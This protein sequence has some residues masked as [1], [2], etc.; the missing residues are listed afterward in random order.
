MFY[1]ALEPYIYD[2]QNRD[3]EARR[4]RRS[5]LSRN[6]PRWKKLQKLKQEVKTQVMLAKERR[7]ETLVNKINKG[8]TGN[9]TWWKL[10]CELYSRKQ[11]TSVVPFVV[12]RKTIGNPVKKAE[13]LNSH[14]MG[15]SNIQGV[16]DPLPDVPMEFRNE[17]SQEGNARV[18]DR[19]QSGS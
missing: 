13:L 7:L 9:K 11:D 18:E 5:S 12:D 10:T 6:N 1:S 14:F 2:R 19:F 4:T 17:N 8:H 3:Y 16:D 15:I